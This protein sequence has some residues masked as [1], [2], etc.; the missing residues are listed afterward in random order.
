MSPIQLQPPN[1]AAPFAP[2]AIGPVTLANPVVLA[3]MSGVTDL[4][5]RTLAHRYGAG[6]VVTEMVASEPLAAERRDMIRKVARPQHTPFVVQL[7]GRE[8]RWMAEGARIAAGEGADIVDI[9]MGCPSK[10]VTNGLSG[11]ALMRDLDHALSLIEAV[12]GAVKVP[13]TV[14]MRMGWDDSNRNAPELARRAEAAGVKAVTVHGRTRCQFFNGRADWAF[15]RK[16][17]EAV[18]IPVTVNGDISTLED[19]ASALQQSAADAV[20]I[21]RGAYGRPWHPGRIAGFLAS[22]RDPGPP[23]DAEQ[24]AV[25][26]EHYEMMLAHYGR[27]LGLR[28]ARKHLV[29]TIEDRF[30]DPLSRK[31]WRQRVCGEDDPKRVLAAIAELF[32]VPVAEAA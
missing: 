14:K 9:N 30:A 27:Q 17:K 31:G 28:N 10:M 25:I 6:M 4:P 22:G 32:G 18:A 3:P 2:F 29:W 5:F 24:A 1:L 23:P 7:A 19:A 16:V 20:M 26:G 8:P 13:V 15:V 12:V 11:S 21:G